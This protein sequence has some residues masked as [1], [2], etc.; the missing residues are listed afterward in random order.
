VSAH[1]DRTGGG[2]SRRWFVVGALAAVAALALS[3]AAAAGPIGAA[4]GFEDD[5]GNLAVDST[6]DWNGFAPVTWTGAAPYQRASKTA[7]GWA[8]GGLSD[9]Q[10]T[11]SDTG[12]AGGTKQDKDCPSVTGTKAPNKD[13]LKRIYLATKT[14]NGHVY[15]NLAWV[16]ITQNTT[17]PSA[18]VGFEFN[19]GTTP[20]PSGSDGLVQRTAGDVLIVYDFEGSSTDVPTLTARRWVTSGACEVSSDSPPC[21]GPAVNL[22]AFGF[23]EA[24]VNTFGAVSDTIG[25]NSPTPES[26]GT[27]E[28][29]EAGIDLTGAGFFPPGVCSAF[30]K[31]SGVSRSSGNS[32][33]AA[34]EDLVGPGDFNINNCVPTTTTTGQKVVITDFARP[35]GF[36]TPTGTVTFQLFTN[37]SCTGTPLYDSGPVALGVDGLASAT[38]GPLTTTGTDTSATFYWLVSY[39]G[40]ANNLPSTS[41]C[42]T[43]QTTISGN[44]PGVDP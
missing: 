38:T 13:D 15:L 35:S 6:F 12:F 40:D 22:T 33:Q 9:A 18:H 31:V 23:A 8:F 11:T 25:P 1:R 19:K 20:C 36:G 16:R 27:S 17:S 24:K 28:F 10:E 14:V 26:L 21:W 5:D 7:S 42:G 44:T 29:G 41:P 37:S 2:R 34:M 43:E 30:G 39:S 32:G 3:V 4:S